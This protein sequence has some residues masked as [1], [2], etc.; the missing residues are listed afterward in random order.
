MF[1]YNICQFYTATLFDPLLSHFCKAGWIHY[2]RDPVCDPTD[3][4]L[5]QYQ[6]NGGNYKM[7][8]PKTAQVLPWNYMLQTSAWY[9]QMQCPSAIFKVF[10]LYEL[11]GSSADAFLIHMNWYTLRFSFREFVLISELKCGDEN[12]PEFTFNTEEPNRLL[13]QYFGGQSKITKRQFVQSFKDKVWGQNDDDV[14]KFAN[15]YFLHNFIISEE[16]SLTKI[17]RKV[18]DFAESGHFVD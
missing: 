15:L 16:P 8:V 11:K 4:M 12:E 2:P 13:A 14:V 9:W 1:D 3:E 5:Y 6:R 10:M 7:F 17:Y 18:F